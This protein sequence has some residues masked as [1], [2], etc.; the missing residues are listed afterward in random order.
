MDSASAV[1]TENVWLASGKSTKPPR[2]S[3]ARPSVNPSD[4]A[5]PPKGNP[6]PQQGYGGQPGQPGYGQ[7]AYG[8]QPGYG[9]PGGIGMVI[10]QSGPL[11]PSSYL[12]FSI[13]M[14]LFCNWVFG[15]IAIILSALSEKD[16]DEGNMDE[17]R[18]KGQA[19]LGLNIASLVIGVLIII[20][21]PIIFFTVLA[22]TATTYYG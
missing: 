19:A 2:P 17:A 22:S 18:Q 3:A 20:I 10:V 4:A 6:P 21:V 13:V 15:I 7:P 5:Y 11:R 1:C 12:A 16:A 8:G 14:C 9:Q